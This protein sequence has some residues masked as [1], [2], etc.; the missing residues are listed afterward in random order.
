MQL[1][2]H[3]ANRISSDVRRALSLV[4]WC[5]VALALLLP[6]S[7]CGMS[8]PATAERKGPA[9][10]IVRKAP[11]AGLHYHVVMPG[12]P[13]REDMEK[14]DMTGYESTVDGVMFVAYEQQTTESDLSDDPHEIEAVLK[15]ACEGFATGAQGV[16][17][18]RISIDHDIWPGKESEGT[19]PAVTNGLY[20]MRVYI[21]PAKGR[22]MYLGVFG[23]KDQVNSAEAAKFFASFAAPPQ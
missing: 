23:P 17:R 16:E 11:L 13:K 20:R 22:T 14:D 1:G 3:N 5:V 15:G 2:S 6:L 10:V 7:G 8:P 4:S 19:L 12:D 18:R 21:D 9:P